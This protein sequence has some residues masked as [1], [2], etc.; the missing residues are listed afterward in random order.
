M[1]PRLPA[2]ILL[3]GLLGS[4]LSAAELYR[5]K[6]ERKNPWKAGFQGVLP[7]PALGHHYAGD[8]ERGKPFFY[9]EAVTAGFAAYIHISE[10][11]SNNK[12]STVQ[13]LLGLLAILKLWEAADAFATADQLNYELRR[14]YQ[15]HELTQVSMFNINIE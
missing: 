3:I 5:Y 15:I 2:M 4:A 1:I 10:A 9:A 12:I 8:W 7:W 13:T 11:E 14:R 6:A